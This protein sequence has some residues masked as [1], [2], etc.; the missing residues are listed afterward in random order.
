MNE[1]PGALLALIGPDIVVKSRRTRT[2][3]IAQLE[4][5]VR[6]ALSRAG[7]TFALRRLGTRFLVET[8]AVD[9]A[10]S[11]LSHVFGLAAICPVDAVCRA[12]PGEIALVGGR[13]FAEAVRG[14]RFAV[15]AKR[16]TPEPF[17]SRDVEVALGAA[18]APLAKV[19][20][21][22]PEVTVRVELVGDTAFLSRE[23]LAGAGG[24]PAGVQGKVLALISGGFDSPVAAWRM[25]RRG[26][27]VH[28]L[29]CSLAGRAQE[30][31]AVQ[32]VKLLCELWAHGTRPRL[33]LVDFAPLVEEL[34]RRTARPYW[35]LVLKVLFYRAASALA[36][37]ERA[38]MVVT[39][40][41]L[42]QVSSQTLAN[43]ATLDRFAEVP[44]LRPLAGFDKAEIVAEARRIGTAPLSERVPELC[45]LSGAKPAIAARVG[46]LEAELAKLEP[47][48]LARALDSR[49]TLDVMALKAED[50]RE[51]YLFVDRFGEGEVVIDCRTPA[52][53]RRW[54][55]PGAVNIPADELM[56][57]W[58]S[59]DRDK[60]YVLYCTFGTRTPLVA[61]LMQQAG[62][63]AYAFRGGIAAVER[64]VEAEWRRAF[65]ET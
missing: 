53:Y 36:R 42:G 18:L 32:V 31:L 52:E 27:E 6:D 16:L 12:D 2:R 33:Y 22:A 25:L 38:D 54:H 62:F 3:F 28:F 41:A 30:R 35:Q 43:L 48:M 49:R 45:G 47:E 56:E 7:S 5:N 29:H 8:A 21:D 65:G 1:R 23:R 11:V 61:E 24:L 58:R 34:K 26:A 19:D 37:I 39:G 64:A 17:T 13:V 60:R 55:V 14:R 46:Q 44:V 57:R 15:R 50:L 40:E 9:A 10:A 59:L 51:P 20:L 4:H 63:D